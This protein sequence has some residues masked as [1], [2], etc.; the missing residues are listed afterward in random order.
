MIW[1]RGCWMVSRCWG[2]IWSWGWMIWC[3]RMIRSWF[4][5]GCMWFMISR[6]FWWWVWLSVSM[7]TMANSCSRVITSSNVFI[8]N[9]AVRAMECILFSMGMTYMVNLQKK[10]SSRET[11]WVSPHFKV[12]NSTFIKKK[13]FIILPYN[14]LQHRHRCVH[15]FYHGNRSLCMCRESQFLLV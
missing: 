6:L 13:Y 12:P 14:Q 15:T 5:I 8:E 3:W 2:M 4:V 11:F 7:F 9:C 10:N 1:F